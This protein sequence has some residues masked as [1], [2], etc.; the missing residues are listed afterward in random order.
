MNY[1]FLFTISFL[2][3][4]VGLS[5]LFFMIPDDTAVKTEQTVEEQPVVVVK[6]TTIT[7]ASLKKDLPKGAL[8]QAEDYIL[9][10][11]D[12]PENDPLVA[13]DIKSL[14]Q[15]Q[16]NFSLQGFLVSENLQA[17]S[18]LS[19][20]RLVAP[21]D[22]R[23]LLFSLDP[24][25][26]VAYRLNIKPNNSYIL[27]TLQIGQSVSL[28]SQ[29]D[30]PYNDQL[31]TQDFVKLITDVPLLGRRAYTWE[32]QEKH[33][34]IAGYVTLKL[35]TE[36]VKTLYSLPKDAVVMVLPEDGKSKN[37]ANHKGSF[38]RKLRG[39]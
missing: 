11:K 8:V 17:G 19:K 26:E 12:V 6:N 13:N 37:S 24:K 32:E 27:D 29:Q 39:Q 23:F 15:E 4:A 16:H 34:G 2:I 18:M 22:P 38:I 5:G 9:S 31:D 36:Q 21:D 28:Y 30:H 1:R 20:E 3:L 25:Q 33:K 7:L 14:L 10:E 35:N